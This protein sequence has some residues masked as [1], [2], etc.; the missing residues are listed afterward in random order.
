[1]RLNLFA[2]AA[3]AGLCLVVLASPFLSMAQAHATAS[4]ARDRDIIVGLHTVFQM[5][6][7]RNDAT[8]M[9]R[10][11]HDRFVLVRGDGERYSRADLLASAA[12]G[13]IA[14]EKQDEDQGTRSVQVLGDTAVITARFWIK[15]VKDG[16]AF[17]RRQ[18]F[19]DVYVR[20]PQGWRFAFCQAS[21]PL[22]D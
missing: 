7:K 20:T 19:S 13:R 8:T 12:S 9:R 18:W 2:E 21:L 11:L 10:I 14:Y 16:V 17:D 5:A 15:G 4:G 3:R 1:M 6:V 22:Q